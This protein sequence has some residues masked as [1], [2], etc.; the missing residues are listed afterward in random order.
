MESPV[1]SDGI[2]PLESDGGGSGIQSVWGVLLAPESTFRSLAARPRW[3]PAFLLLFLSA[4]GLSLILMPRMDMKQVIRD[5][6]EKQ[7][8]EISETKLDSQVRLAKIVGTASQVVVQP[9]FY[10]ILASVFLVVF[11]LSGSEIDFRRSLSVTVHGMLPV[12]VAS[13]LTIPIL[14]TRTKISMDE[15]KSGSFLPSNLGFLATEST[16]KALHSLLSS[17]DIFSLWAIALLAIGF[18]IVGRVSTGVAWGVV[19]T[20]WALAIGAKAFLGSLY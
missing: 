1:Q 11:R 9:A 15:A 14:L 5:A 4:V 3:F 7:G 17:C 20:L 19:L 16:G 6:V 8:Q 13:L 12:V 10:L 2:E 18:R